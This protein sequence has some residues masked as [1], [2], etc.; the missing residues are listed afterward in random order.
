MFVSMGRTRTEFIFDEVAR[1]VIPNKKDIGSLKAIVDR[2]ELQGKSILEIGCGIGD[3]LIYCSHKGTKYAEGF[4]ISSENIR[5]A[6]QKTKGCP[7]I[8]FHKCSI[9]DYNS[10]RKFD[11]VLVWGVF[12]Y[13]DSPTESLKKILSFLDDNGT[14]I[15]LISKPI[16]I[17]K[18]SFL[19][20]AVLSRIPRRSVLPTAKFLSIILNIFKLIFKKILY[21]GESNTYT[22]EQTILEGL[23]V[24][25][26]NIFHHNVFTDYLQDEKFVVEFLNGVTPSMTCMVASKKRERNED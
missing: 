6:K 10:D 16:L 1:E 19:F 21:T 18:I 12:E 14:I 2:F 25:K 20:R 22:M 17:K 24:P 13:V 7:K 23:M 26:Y 4:D 9:E 15:L 5:I 11:F 3:N 8:S